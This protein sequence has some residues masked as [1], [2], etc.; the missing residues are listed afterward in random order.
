[1][2]RKKLPLVAVGALAIVAMFASTALAGEVTGRDLRDGVEP[3]G[4]NQ[5]MSW[6]SFSGL[7]D[8]PEASTV[9][10]EFT[11]PPGPGGTSQSFGQEVK[12][13]LHDP[14]EGGPFHP[15]EAC[16]P[17]KSILGPQPNRTK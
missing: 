1:V 15:G 9:P 7:N 17:T 14:S 2:R 16:N 5:G 3:R 11:V 13:G 6:C 4:Q 8:V 10:G 12:L